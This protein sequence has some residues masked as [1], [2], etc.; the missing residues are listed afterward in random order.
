MISGFRV[1]IWFVSW[2]EWNFLCQVWK[3]LRIVE[4]SSLLMFWFMLNSIEK[5]IRLCGLVNMLL[6]LVS[7]VGV[8]KK[9]LLKLSKNW[10]NINCFGWVRVLDWLLS[11]EVIMISVSVV[12]VG[13]QSFCGLSVRQLVMILYRILVK[14]DYVRLVICLFCRLMYCSQLMI[15]VFCFVSMMWINS[16]IRFRCMMLLLESYLVLSRGLLWLCLKVIVVMISIIVVVSVQ[17]IY[18]VLNYYLSCF[19]DSMVYI[20]VM[21]GVSR[22]K[23]M[24]FFFLNIFL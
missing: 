9:V 17:L 2:L 18:G 15:L 14:I 21:L 22:K 8:R 12:V 13:Q 23:V 24:K 3:V 11:S 1:V 5:L 10:L 19:S 16:I 20:S 4:L 6:I 7:I